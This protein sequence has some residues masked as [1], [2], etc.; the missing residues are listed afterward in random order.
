MSNETYEDWAILLLKSCLTCL[1][2]PP[3]DIPGLCQRIAEG[4]SLDLLSDLALDSL[5]AMEF[6]IQFEIESTLVL[7]PEDL[8]DAQTSTDLLK[9]MRS[10]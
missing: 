5:G 8:I 1:S 3:S 4:Q 6:C 9:I 7:T 10:L 2:L